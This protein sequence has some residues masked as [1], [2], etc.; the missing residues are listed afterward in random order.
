MLLKGRSRTL[1][2]QRVLLT[3]APRM[4]QEVP[5]GAGWLWIQGPREA[6]LTHTSL[7]RAGETG[8]FFLPS[9]E[10]SKPPARR[11]VWKERRAEPDPEQGWP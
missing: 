9:S 11:E 10:L 4:G 1:K 6:V 8:S 2:H 5:T 3:P 7:G